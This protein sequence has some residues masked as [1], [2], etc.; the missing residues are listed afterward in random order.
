ME[1][2]NSLFHRHYLHTSQSLTSF[3]STATSFVSNSLPYSLLVLR[4]TLGLV[5]PHGSP[6]DTEAAQQDAFF[7]F[8]TILPYHQTLTTNPMLISELVPIRTMDLLLFCF[9]DLH[10]PVSRS[11]LR[12]LH[13]SQNGLQ[14]PS[15]HPQ[16]NLT[17][18][19]QS[20]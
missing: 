7:D 1:K 13:R 4:L 9:N 3:N 6:L 19:P 10:N 18:L 12:L 20:S 11:S 5:V 8:S 17:P 14:S 16:P 2:P 15:N